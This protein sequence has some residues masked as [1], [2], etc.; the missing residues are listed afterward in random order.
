MP[1]QHLQS[2]AELA[3]G[4]TLN[5]VAEGLLIAL[6]GWLLLRTMRERNSN[7]RFAVL[8]AT[9]AAVASMPIIQALYSSGNSAGAS[10]FAFHLPASWAT[11][12]FLV[13][14]VIAIAG[15]A[16]VAL[17]FWQLHKLRQSCN[18]LSLA[19]LPDLNAAA[20]PDRQSRRVQ[21][22]VCNRVRVPAAIGF[23]RPAI[24]IPAW[25]LT[26]LTPA[27]LNSVI[28]HELAHLRRWDDWTNLAQ[29]IVSAL[30]FFHPA[31]W[32]IDRG[33][34]RE[35]E[36]AC[37]DFVLAATAD[38]RGYAKCLVSVAE[39]SFL[40]RGLALAQAMAERM[41]LTAQRVARILHG[42]C[43][44]E[45]PTTTAVWKPAVAFLA[46]VSAVCLVSLAYEPSFIAFDNGNGAGTVIAA[47]APQ[48]DAKVIPAK[49][50]VR[51]PANAAHDQPV[52]KPTLAKHVVRHQGMPAISLAAN[53]QNQPAQMLVRMTNANAQDSVRATTPHTVLVIMQRNEVDAYGR[54]WS[55]SVWQLTVYHPDQPATRQVSKGVPPKST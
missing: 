55:V 43:P 25:A 14:A 5:G 19:D 18:A 27:E 11:D 15:L 42:A 24:V 21:I 38:H 32:W 31:V 29:K 26:E 23:I 36:M 1:A 51:N 22:C 4:R 7:T 44:E 39:K 47:Q 52:A 9:L 41:Q 8:L 35:R 12:I 54:V 13:W 20:S 16:K 37:D 10:N 30:L 34:T 46:A 33:L 49:F 45:K 6:C 48:F 53:N 50:V 3:I 17:G 2:V 40:R 28:L